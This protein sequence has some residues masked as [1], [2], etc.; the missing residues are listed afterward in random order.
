MQS[1]GRWTYVELMLA[2]MASREADT[3]LLTRHG[4]SR[5][6]SDLARWVLL[7]RS[8]EEALSI[9]NGQGRGDANNVLPLA[10]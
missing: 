3:L 9:L 2:Q 8:Y 5:L 6:E 4:K 1:A 10:R 7:G